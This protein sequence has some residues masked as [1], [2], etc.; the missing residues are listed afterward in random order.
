MNLQNTA[1]LEFAVFCMESLAEHFH[2]DGEKIYRALT[3]KSQILN[4]Y[5]IPLYDT[6]HTQGKEYIV[7][8]I[9]ELMQ[10]RGVEV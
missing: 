4:E 10:E 2:T 7:N 6:L 3:E 5:I 1:Q 8:D 9:A